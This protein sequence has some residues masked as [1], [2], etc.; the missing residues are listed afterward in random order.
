MSQARHRTYLLKGTLLTGVLLAFFLAVL[1]GG[2]RAQAQEVVTGD[3]VLAAAG[4]IAQCTSLNDEATAALLG[5]MPEA[6]VATLGDATYPHG[7]DQDY[8]NCYEPSW[9]LYKTQTLPTTGNHDYDTA[10]ASGYF[11]YFGATLNS[12]GAAAAD[13]TKGYYSYDLGTWHVV[14][15]NSNCSKVV[16]G[17]A[18]TSPQVQW[19][20]ADLAAHP[21]ACTLAYWHEPRFSSIQTGLRL[22]AFWNALYK[23]KAEVVLNG[24]QHNY[25]RFAPQTPA[26][27]ADPASGIREFVVGTGGGTLN[28]FNTT[29]M[30]NSEVREASTYG[31][32]KLTLHPNS[33]DWEFVPVAGQTFT[34]SGTTSCRAADTSA[35]LAQPPSQSIPANSTLEASA[36]SAIP[37]K[38]S[39]SAT[40]D[41]G[42]SGY[43]LQQSTD[44]GATFQDVTLASPKATSTTLQLQPGGTY[45]FRVQAT[46]GAGNRSEW[47][48]GPSFVVGPEQEDGGAVSYAG[49]WTPLASDAAYGGAT[50][51]SQTK[52]STAGFAFSGRNVAWVATK[53]PDGGKARVLLDGTAIATVDLY[54]STSQPRKVVFSKGGLDPSVA[55]TLTVQVLGT[56]NASSSSTRVD[57]DGF[58]ALR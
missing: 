7:S 42:V 33:Y 8:L 35:P 43:V 19:L 29:I 4:D 22:T 46:D 11:N 34:D 9:G 24:H 23:A 15:L 16:G 58:V 28:A 30:A 36:T 27:K 52:N 20:N 48:S 5:T 57:V 41:S 14:V 39:W 17:C 3:P 51:Q 54:A 45:Q 38:L 44:E 32:L 49:S 6:T 12:F 31:V 26:G 50:S 47:A 40:D 21:S 2:A 25:E 18:A 53:G 56:K 13:P 37:V 1:S 55:H 10:R